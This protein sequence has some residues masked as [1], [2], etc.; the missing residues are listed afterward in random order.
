MS[1]LARAVLVVLLAAACAE[2]AAASGG[3]SR[4]LNFDGRGH[5]PTYAG[6]EICSGQIP[7]FDGSTMDVDVTRARGPRPRRGYPLVVMVHGAAGVDGSKREFESVNDEA[8]GAER[9][10]WNSNWFARHGF[11]VLTFTQRGYRTDPPVAAYQP[12]TPT[13]TS[14]EVP[15][16]TIHL[17]SREFSLRDTQWLAA[18]VAKAFDVDRRRIVITG[19]ASGG[20]EAWLLAAKRLWLDPHRRDP[21]LPVLHLQAALPRTGWTDLLYSMAPNGHAGGPHRDDLL[22][23]S[24]GDPGRA[25]GADG[26]F[27]LMKESY[28]TAISGLV[29]RY[30]VFEM[31]TTRTPSEEG[32][33]NVFS[34]FA[35]GVAG[36][37]Y[38]DPLADQIKRGLSEFRSAY[39]QDQDWKTQLRGRK[40]PIFSIQGWTDQLFTA[41]ESLRENE[42]LKRLDRRWP[43]TLAFANVGN[44]NAGNPPPVWRALNAQSWRWLRDVLRGR[45][46]GRHRRTPAVTSYPTQCQAAAAAPTPITASSPTRLARGRLVVAYRDGALLTS[47]SGAGDRNGPASDPLASDPGAAAS[48]RGKCLTSPGPATGAYTALSDPLPAAATYLG[49]GSVSVP[50]ALTGDRASLD[51]RLWDAG[52][53]AAP[54]LITRGTYVLDTRAGDPS[55]G[56]LRMPLFGNHWELLPGHRLRLDLTQVD[57]PYLRPVSTPGAL[58]LEPPTLTLPT[59]QPGAVRLTGALASGV[60]D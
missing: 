56:T 4:Y 26:P 28:M 21:S 35:R 46:R 27:G 25:T 37:P 40:V 20:G 51:A 3:A 5:C 45:S 42:Y 13:G 14:M 49:L 43:V 16:G 55:S 2:P 58:E 54:V 7:S 41:V 38:G 10:R 50:Y 9:Y 47:S 18:Q 22:E 1:G 34:W 39:Y 11:Y 59:R 32:P 6:S 12:D 60:G 44:P 48:G 15:N 30:G 31:G 8:S 19:R 29:S 24:S 53:D 36:D 52:P 57:H 23:A 17:T 33:V